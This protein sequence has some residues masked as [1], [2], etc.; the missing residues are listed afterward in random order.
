VQTA[1]KK[2]WI[3]ISILSGI[4]L[5]T[6]LLFLGSKSLWIDECLAWGAVRL[7]WVEMSL[8]VAAGTPHPPLAF[9]IIKLSSMIAGESEFGLRLLVAV[10]VA[11]AVIPVFRLVSR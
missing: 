3:L 11:S 7:S 5:L 6:R 10:S 4:S 9:A 1:E 2:S 8:K